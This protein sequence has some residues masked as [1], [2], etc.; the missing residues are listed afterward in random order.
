[1]EQSRESKNKTSYLWLIDFQQKCQ[2]N[3][4]GKRQSFQQMGWAT[5]YSRIKKPN[6]NKKHRS[7]S[8]AINKN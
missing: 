7:L 1:M 6:Q 3:S 8:H 2:G 4:V 5:E